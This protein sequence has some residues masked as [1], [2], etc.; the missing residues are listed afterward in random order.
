MV[1]SAGIA[2]EIAQSQPIWAT[3]KSTWDSTIDVNLTGLFKCCQAATAQ[4]LKQ[5]PLPSGSRG[6]VVNLSSIYGQTAKAGS[7]KLPRL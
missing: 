1:N 2:P 4:M 3:S 5:D 6:W 7:G